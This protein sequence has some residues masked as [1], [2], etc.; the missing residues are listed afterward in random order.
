MLVKVVIVFLAVMVVI[1]WI[2]GALGRLRL[3][4]ADKSARLDRYC[5][6]CGRPRVGKGP[7]PCGQ[8]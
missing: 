8:A 3:P 7:C 4:G 2:G 5:S 1:A 6:S